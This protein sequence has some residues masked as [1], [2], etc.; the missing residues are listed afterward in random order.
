MPRRY[1]ILE[2]C[3]YGHSCAC[4]RGTLGC[5]ACAAAS[6]HADQ[7]QQCMMRTGPH[8]FVC[9]CVDVQAAPGTASAAECA[10]GF[11]ALAHAHM[12]VA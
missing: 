7:A 11:T 12:L 9:C 5:A 6:T 4:L 10:A 2:V 8:R 1:M 3:A